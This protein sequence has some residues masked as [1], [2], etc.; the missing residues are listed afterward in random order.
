MR[1]VEHFTINQLNS[2]LE[3]DQTM[4]TESRA[5]E[6]DLQGVR[7]IYP[8]IRAIPTDSLTKNYTLYTRAAALDAGTPEVPAGYT[9][10]VQP[11]AKPVITAHNLHGT[12]TTSPDIPM[13]RVIWSGWK[14]RTRD[15]TITYIP[16]TKKASYQ[17]TGYMAM[18]AAITDPQAIERV[19]NGIYS[20][21]SIGTMANSVTESISGTDLIEAQREGKAMPRYIR[22][23]EYD[24]KL[25]YYIVN[26]FEAQEISYV[27][28]PA[29]PL[30][31]NMV[32][33]IGE[34][35]VKLLL[36]ERTGKEEFKFY[37]IVTKEY[38]DMSE[39][40]DFAFDESFNF[41]DS[42]APTNKYWQMNFE[43]ER[44]EEGQNELEA[45][46][47]LYCE[48]FDDELAKKGEWTLQDF[49]TADEA[50]AQDTDNS[51]EEGEDPEEPET[52]SLEELID[53]VL[54]KNE[55]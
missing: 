39:V 23:Q 52:K 36:G 31:G 5:A 35:K 21:V 6:L 44:E 22:G 20:T 53:E 40:T 49:V 9:S 14:R 29:A 54:D 50:L 10:F 46:K 13:G 32:K 34:A 43:P 16:G 48:S 45:I 19:L 1:L 38:V 42:W 24:G 51:M 17:G 26:G 30:A 7:A 55:G 28:S 47:A 15:E 37:D 25:C 8:L 41:K 4:L 18:V 12:I 33:D 3:P 11:Y 2:V 27:N